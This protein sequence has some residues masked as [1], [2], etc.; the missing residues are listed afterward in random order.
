[1]AASTCQKCGKTSFEMAP[2]NIAKSTHQLF[3]IQ[4]ASCGAVVGIQESENLSHSLSALT[5][6]IDDIARKIS[7][8]AR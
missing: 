8:I 2:A 7:L 6:K 3:F 4:C 1:M 5:K